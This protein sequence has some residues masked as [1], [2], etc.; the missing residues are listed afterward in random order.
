MAKEKS[1]PDNHA[2]RVRRGFVKISEI[3]EASEMLRGLASRLDGMQ[4]RM[5]DLG[6]DDM[7]VDGVT[8]YDRGVDLLGSYIANVAAALEKADINSMKGKG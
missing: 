6:I 1:P 2:S 7:K 3:S 8:K 5:K 4:V